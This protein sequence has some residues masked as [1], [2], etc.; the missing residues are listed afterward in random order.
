MI[1]SKPIVLQKNKTDRNTKNEYSLKGILIAIAIIATWAISLFGLIQVNISELS[2]WLIF[3]AILWQTFLYTGL[4]ITAHDA[5]HGVVFPQNIKLNNL[6][7][8]LTL[9]LYALFSYDKL[10]KKHWLHHHNPASK[11]DPDFHDGKHKNLLAWYFNFLKGY[12]DW[13]QAV[14]LILTFHLVRYTLHIPETNLTLFWAVPAILSSVQLFYFGTFLPHREP[15]GGYQNV[16]RSQSISLPVFWSFIS[17]YH[18]GYHE[19][20]H[21]FPH[22]PWWE[23]P[24]TY[25]MKQKNERIEPV[26][27]S[28]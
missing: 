27:S 21:E 26:V 16:H 2:D 9:F 1:E 3:L 6:I 23:L 14:G 19:E 22:V 5:M 20:H 4:F 8:K 28:Q 24:K 7:G 17:C 25:H 12:W 11:N 13:K 18:F 10:L 15:E